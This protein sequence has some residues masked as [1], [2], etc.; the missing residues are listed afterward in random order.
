MRPGRSCGENTGPKRVVDGVF[1]AS[2]HPILGVSTPRFEGVDFRTKRLGFFRGG[3]EL[4]AGPDG[5]V[6]DAGHGG[7]GRSHIFVG[8]TG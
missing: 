6:R 5:L 8:W 2:Q 1:L 4:V 3:G 7:S